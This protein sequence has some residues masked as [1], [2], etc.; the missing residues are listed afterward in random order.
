MV[1]ARVCCQLN[2]VKIKYRLANLIN[3]SRG[4]N[5]GNIGVKPRGCANGRG[6]AVN[7]ALD[8]S[9]YPRQKLVPSSLF[10]KYLVVKKCNN[11]N[12]GLVTPSSG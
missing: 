7:S 6:S 8:G 2:Q 12:L 3:L 4:T 1:F 11:L 5:Y 9:I 10:K